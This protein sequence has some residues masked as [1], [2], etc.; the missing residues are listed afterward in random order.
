[1]NDLEQRMDAT[2]RRNE[3]RMKGDHKGCINLILAAIPTAAAS[4]IVIGRVA[5][6]W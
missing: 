1:M 2:R 5:G 4:V 3:V 6:W